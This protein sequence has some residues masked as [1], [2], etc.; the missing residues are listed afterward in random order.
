MFV[1]C[2][3]FG[4]SFAAVTEW[5]ASLTA[6]T[7]LEWIVLVMIDV[8]LSMDAPT[9]VPPVS[10]KAL[11]VRPRYPDV[12]RHAIDTVLHPDDWF[13]FAGAGVRRSA[14]DAHMPR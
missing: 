10:A 9:A 8:P 14:P 3:E 7:A 4:A 5:A 11:S 6:V 1:E 12:H 13:R 2:T